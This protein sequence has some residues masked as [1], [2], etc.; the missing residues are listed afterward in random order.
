[1]F[2]EH[3]S[4]RDPP[5]WTCREAGVEAITSFHMHVR[6]NGKYYGKFGYSEQIDEDTLEVG[7]HFSSSHALDGRPYL[8]LDQGLLQSGPA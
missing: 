6:Y 4:N 5:V 1:M 2:Q 8:L 7:M 3:D